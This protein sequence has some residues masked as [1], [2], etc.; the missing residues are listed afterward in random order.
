M[1]LRRSGS[2]GPRSLTGP[3]FL[4][5]VIASTSTVAALT[6]IN[7]C[8]RRWTRVRRRPLLTQRS[9]SIADWHLLPRV[10][11]RLVPSLPAT[12]I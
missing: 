7:R 4:K 6:A 12:S 1:I 3:M 11:T 10:R 2:D 9:A 5:S 8:L